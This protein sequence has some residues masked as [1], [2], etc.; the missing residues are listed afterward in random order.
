[1]LKHLIVVACLTAPAMAV[2]PEWNEGQWGRFLT[3]LRETETGGCKNEGIN[4][5]GDNGTSYGPLQISKAAFID[6]QEY[7][8][9]LKNNKWDE[10]KNDLL[11]SQR[12]AKAY[13]KRYL[14]KKDTFEDAARLWNSGPKYKE[15]HHLTNKYVK[16]FLSF[17]KK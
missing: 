8:K 4:A 7:D 5:V 3:A 11:L 15:K 9:T 16:R 12:V 2:D 10:C 17:W 14:K 6:A 13:I 1:M